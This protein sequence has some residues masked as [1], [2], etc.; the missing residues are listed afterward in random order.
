MTYGPAWTWQAHRLGVRGYSARSSHT[1]RCRA[2]A[3]PSTVSGPPSAGS[4][5]SYS[6]RATRAPILSSTGQSEPTTWGKPAIWKALAMCTDSSAS[7]A[8]IR[9]VSQADR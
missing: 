9:M 6:P 1:A 5:R 4:S 2:R 3:V 8:L 7:S